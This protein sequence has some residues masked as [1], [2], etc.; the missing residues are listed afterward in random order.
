MA[1]W[2]TRPVVFTDDVKRSLGFYVDVVGFTKDWHEGDGT[3]GVCQVSRDGCEII[4]CE[5][6]SRR[7]RGRLFVSLDDDGI[8][9]LRAAIA[10]KSIAHKQSWWGMDVIEI[11]DPDGNQ[12][13]FSYP[14]VTA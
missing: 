3:G 5:D 2:Y 12:L 10:A 6:K 7:D 4:L 11:D 1:R 9:M 8:A 13:M 14:V